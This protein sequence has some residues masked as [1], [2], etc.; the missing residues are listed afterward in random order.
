MFHKIVTWRLWKR[1]IFVLFQNNL[2]DKIRSCL[3]AS[4]CH[5]IFL[6]SFLS[7]FLENNFQISGNDFWLETL[8][9]L[10]KW[11]HFLGLSFWP[12]KQLS[13]KWLFTKI[14][15]TTWECLFWKISNLT[16]QQV[17]MIVHSTHHVTS[18][19]PKQFPSHSF[20]FVIFNFITN[21]KPANK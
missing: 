11:L 10:W 14:F 6:L 20:F 18:Y 9:S 12:K 8:I 15:T 19:H 17:L 1:E 13:Q 3:N 5:G 21:H 4:I 2:F 16:G 7:H